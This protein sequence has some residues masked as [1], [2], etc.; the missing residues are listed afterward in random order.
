ML[1]LESWGGDGEKFSTL[2]LKL[3]F[4]ESVSELLQHLLILVNSSS[5]RKNAWKSTGVSV[6]EV[7]NHGNQQHLPAEGG[8]KS[9]ICHQILTLGSAVGGQAAHPRFPKGA[10]WMPRAPI[11]CAPWEPMRAV[12]TLGHG[13]QGPGARLSH[14]V[15]FLQFSQYPAP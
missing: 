15:V 8:N 12:G 2:S 7:Q 3:S 13:V 9:A 11:P 5:P 4:Y 14:G 10:P 1:K 6:Q